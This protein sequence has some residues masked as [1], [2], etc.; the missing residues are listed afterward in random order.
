LME[1]MGGKRGRHEGPEKM[2]KGDKHVRN[3]ETPPEL[4]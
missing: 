2:D 4:Y 3:A 1:H